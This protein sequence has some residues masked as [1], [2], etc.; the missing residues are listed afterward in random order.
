MRYIDPDRLCLLHRYLIA[1]VEADLEGAEK[2][3]VVAD[4]PLHT[5]PF[6][7]MVRPM[8]EAQRTDFV[9]EQRASDGSAEHPYLAE[10]KGLP[11]LGDQYRFAY[12][13]SLAA[14]A[15]QRLYPKAR[16][17]GKTDL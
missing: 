16:A 1:P 6:E 8:S 17:K 2:V 7:L 11:Y 15:S 3:F 4:G 12:L 5:L 14:L 13:P 10:Y 9:R